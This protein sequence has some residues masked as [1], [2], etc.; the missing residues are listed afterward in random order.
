[1]SLVE[2]LAGWTDVDWAQYELGRAIGLFADVS[3]QQ[4]KSVFWTDN[5]LGNALWEALHS[6]VRGGVL[7]YRDE[8]DHQFRW[9]PTAPVTGRPVTT[10]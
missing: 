8:P 9:S 3:I 4:A 7:E 10:A 5:P 2:Q 1:M 6:L